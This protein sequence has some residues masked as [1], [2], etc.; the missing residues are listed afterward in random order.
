MF[1][2]KLSLNTLVNQIQNELAISPKVPLE[3][4][5]SIINNVEQLIYSEI[6]KEE[7]K[8]ELMPD[9]HGLCRLT[10]I[11]VGSGEDTP[12]V[13]DITQI[14]SSDRRE[15][16]KQTESQSFI[17]NKRPSY[18]AHAPHELY[19]YDTDNTNGPITVFYIARPAPK[20]LEG[21]SIFPDVIYLPDEFTSLIASRIRGEL[22]KIVGDDTQATKWLNDYNTY[23]DDFSNF[24][25]KR[26]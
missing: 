14:F 23:L 8:S 17:M 11:E 5:I 6:I 19:I 3:T 26:G 10:D 21:A 18:V 16:I 2:S 1:S 9:N 15:F 12:R 20:V 22:L 24:I 13:S 25:S 4:V 7:R